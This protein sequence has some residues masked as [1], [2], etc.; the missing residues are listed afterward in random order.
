L[1]LVNL[2]NL[3]SSWAGLEALEKVCLRR[4]QLQLEVFLVLQ[5]LLVA[6]SPKGRQQVLL[7]ERWGESALSLL[8]L[9][10]EPELEERY[11]LKGER[12]WSEFVELELKVKV[13]L[14]MQQYRAVVGPAVLCWALLPQEQ[15]VQVQRL[16]LELEGEVQLEL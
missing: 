14:A 8:E 2:W 4:N 15:V 5:A 9:V 1:D 13:P 7:G 10:A 16:Q 3:L 12:R 6:L 11:F